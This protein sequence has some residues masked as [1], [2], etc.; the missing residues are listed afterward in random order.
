MGTVSL[1]HSWKIPVFW[2]VTANN[3]VSIGNE[4]VKNNLKQ[5]TAITFGKGCMYGSGLF[6]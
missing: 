1:F 3:R 5:K 4:K 6:Y 2:F